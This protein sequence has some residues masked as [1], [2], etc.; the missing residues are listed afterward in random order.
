MTYRFAVYIL[1]Y[2]LDYGAYCDDPY[3]DSAR[4]VSLALI[5]HFEKPVVLGASGEL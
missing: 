4:S 3:Y 5:F 1:F 2:F